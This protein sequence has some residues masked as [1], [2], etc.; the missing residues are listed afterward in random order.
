MWF[1]R[2]DYGLLGVCRRCGKVA[3]AM[4]RLYMKMQVVY[5]RDGAVLIKNDGVAGPG[6]IKGWGKETASQEFA[7]GLAAV[8]EKEC[9]KE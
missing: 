7:E 9:A 6:P 1:C 5:E 3:P 2:H 8:I 4:R